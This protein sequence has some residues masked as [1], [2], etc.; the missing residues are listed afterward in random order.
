MLGE[1]SIRRLHICP[2][3]EINPNVHSLKWRMVSGLVG[4][5]KK[6][7]LME[8]WDC[9]LVSGNVTFTKMSTKVTI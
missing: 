7:Y 4:G 6:Q 3:Q 2:G 1:I 5:R 8:K 9:T